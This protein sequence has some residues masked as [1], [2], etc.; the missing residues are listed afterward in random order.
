MDIAINIP[1][2]TLSLFAAFSVLLFGCIIVCASICLQSKSQ[3]VQTVV[4]VICFVLICI[5]GTTLIGSTL[6]DS[7]EIRV[8]LFAA[9]SEIEQHYGISMDEEVRAATIDALSNAYENEGED[10]YIGITD[11]TRLFLNISNVANVNEKDD[12][13]LRMHVELIE[14]TDS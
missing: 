6:N 10:I 3:R 12:S 2:S 5:F 13:T 4:G 1:D 9:T 14:S 11:S 7:K 8:M